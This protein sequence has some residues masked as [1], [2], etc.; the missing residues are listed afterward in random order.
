MRGANRFEEDALK[1]GR[2]DLIFFIREEKIVRGKRTRTSLRKRRKKRETRANK[3]RAFK[4][5]IRIARINIMHKYK[6]K[7]QTHTYL[8]S[9]CDTQ[10]DDRPSSL[11]S[12]FDSIFHSLSFLLAYFSLFLN[13]QNHW[14]SFPPPFPRC[15]VAHL[16]PKMLHSSFSH[17]SQERY[18]SANSLQAPKHTHAFVCLYHSRHTHTR[19][20]ALLNKA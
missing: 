4:G 12:A 17:I 7:T 2:D 14:P 9:Y 10:L 8:L 5:S 1:H 3:E 15:R 19:T 13:A 11:G 18:N 6:R 20:R 16:W